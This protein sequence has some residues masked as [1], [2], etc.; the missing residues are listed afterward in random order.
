MLK[1]YLYVVVVIFSLLALDGI[2]M[3]KW[4]K[5]NRYF[6]ARLLYFF[7]SMALSYLVVNFLY[8]FFSNS[9]FI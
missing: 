9:K 4:F 2:N 5:K 3:D 7:L 8:D 1:A 6:Q